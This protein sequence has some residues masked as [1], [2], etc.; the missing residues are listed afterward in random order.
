MVLIESPRNL[1]ADLIRS[2]AHRVAAQPHGPSQPGEHGEREWLEKAQTRL[3][4]RMGRQLQQAREA[5][6]S[7]IRDGDRAGWT[8]GD[9]P[10]HERCSLRFEER[11][12]AQ[13]L[14]GHACPRTPK[15]TAARCSRVRHRAPV[16]NASRAG[17][18]ADTRTPPLNAS[19]V[20]AGDSVIEQLYHVAACTADPS[21][22]FYRPSLNVVPPEPL[23]SAQLASIL[24]PGHLHIFS[25]GLWYNWNASAAAAGELATAMTADG[26]VGPGR[27]P[28]PEATATWTEAQTRNCSAVRHID[29][30]R[31]FD[32]RAYAYARRACG[33]ISLGL[34]A[35]VSD[36]RR[37]DVALRAT[38]ARL[39]IPW[40]DIIWRT[41]TPQH[42]RD[43]PGGFYASSLAAWPAAQHECAPLDTTEQRRLAWQRNAI[44]DAVLNGPAGDGRPRE[45]YAR[46][47]TWRTDLWYHDQHSAS[48]GIRDCTHFCLHSDAMREWLVALEKV[49]CE[50]SHEM[51]RA[52]VV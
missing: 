48:D 32:A 35:F 21:V 6:T 42:Y 7:V 29:N 50:R 20:L 12:T 10:M 36:L 2:G 14:F 11:F 19:V 13:H 5:S 52:G 51:R 47:D 44:A 28:L 46:M 18:T 1:S 25:F 23:L 26:D 17:A 9:N 30:A 40:R 27:A 22:R 41:L 15:G 38:A 31:H 49:V 43:S 3:H 37:F 16:R 4:G 8:A 39:S 33:E 24:R 45:P 34:H